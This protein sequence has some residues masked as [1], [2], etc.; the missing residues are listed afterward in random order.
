MQIHHGK[1]LKKCLV[2]NKVTVNSGFEWSES[3]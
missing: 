1:Y 3:E 2:G